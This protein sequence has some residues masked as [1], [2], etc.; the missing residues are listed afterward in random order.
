MVAQ[1]DGWVLAEAAQETLGGWVGGRAPH[2]PQ[3]LALRSARGSCGALPAYKAPRS[4]G[5]MRKRV[6]ALVAFV[7]VLQLSLTAEG[8]VVTISF[9]T[10]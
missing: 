3:R 10:S 2:P 1:G 6:A 5:T 4:S 9:C 7:F 8:A